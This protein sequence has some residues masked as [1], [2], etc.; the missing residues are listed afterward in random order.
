MAVFCVPQVQKAAD[1]FAALDT[2]GGGTICYQELKD[3]LA[4]FNI[5]LDAEE[6]D[7]L[8]LIMDYDS[9]GEIDFAE[10]NDAFRAAL[11]S[12]QTQ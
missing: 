2:D 3:G 6:F 10:F 4:R 1:F 11:E 8:C 7:E 9:D 5:H 12:V